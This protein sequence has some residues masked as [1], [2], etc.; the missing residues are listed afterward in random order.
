MGLRGEA[1][2]RN[3][4]EVVEENKSL[5]SENSS[6]VT[7]SSIRKKRA[8]TT[9]KDVCLQYKDDADWISSS[10]PFMYR[11][12]PTSERTQD[13]S[14]L[15]AKIFKEVYTGEVI[16]E[17][18]IN[19]L[20]KS[21]GGDNEY[22]EK[23][24]QQLQ[25]IHEE[26]DRRIA[27]ADTIE[28]HI[29]Q[30]RA[31]A[32]AAE[33]KALNKEREA[34][35]GSFDSLDLPSGNA[36]LFA[37]FS[38]SSAA[39]KPI[40]HY[41]ELTI[42]FKQ[43]ISQSP[44]DDGYSDQS[45]S[46]DHLTE[47]RSS[48]ILQSTS[49]EL[50]SLKKSSPQEEKS[51]KPRWRDE[52]SVADRIKAREDMARF[53]RCHNFLKNPRFLP[54]QQGGKSLII[55]KKKVQ[56][57]VG[58]RKI[59]V[60]ESDPGEPIPVFLAKPPIIL[61]TDYKVGQ[62][63]ETNVE[64]RNMTSSSRHLRI[65]PPSTT[66]FSVGLGKFPGEGGI[67]APGMS[68]QYT[69]RFAPDSPAEF[70]DFL[71]VETQTPYPLVIPIEARR[72][73]PILTLP[74]T[75]DCGFCLMGGVKFTEFLCR[76]EGYN[77]GCFCIM[78]KRMWPTTNF[79][80][81]AVAGFLD[82]TP[83]A[84]RPAVFELQPGQALILEVA[85]LPPTP[86]T[87]SQTVT[88]V[89]DNCHVKDFVLTGSGQQVAL[90]FMS[91]SGAESTANLGECR[92][93]TA[94]HFVR[95]EATNPHVCSQKVITL[96]NATHIDLP[97]CWQAL[98]PN[99]VCAIP[100]ESIEYPNLDYD[101]DLK[102]AFHVCPEN[103]VMEPHQDHDFVLTYFPQELKEYHSVL[104]LILRNIPEPSN[105]NECN[106]GSRKNSMERSIKAAAASGGNII[107]LEM[108][109][110]GTTEPFQV[111][112]KP[113]A[114]LIPGDNYMHTTLKR[115]FQIWNNS[116]SS[117]YFEW[118]RMHDSHILEVLPPCGT[119]EGNDYCELELLL[120]GGKPEKMAQRLQC[121][122]QHHVEPVILH[123]EA[124]FVGPRVCID[125]P[126]LDFCLVKFG[127]E[128]ACS[129]HLK[130]KCQL[131]ASWFLQESPA[132]LKEREEEVSQFTFEPSSGDLPPLSEYTVNV[133]FTPTKCQ[134]L[135]TVLE[136]N[137]ENG[138]A[139]HI[140]VKAEVQDV[141]VCLLSCT[142]VFKDIY[143]GIP[144]Q[145][146]A[147]LFNQTLLPAK[148]SWGEVH[149]SHVHQCRIKITPTSFTLGPNEKA[150]VCV[151]LTVFS[152]ED[153]NGA[154]VSCTVEDMNEPLLLELFA[155]PKGLNITYSIPDDDYVNESP[156]LD[157]SEMVVHGTVKRKLLIT[158]NSAITGHFNLEMEYFSSCPP[159]PPT[160]SMLPHSLSPRHSRLPLL[161][162][163]VNL[164]EGP[165]KSQ[166]QLQREF[167]DVLLCHK[168][169]A[170]FVV[171][172]VTGTLEPY[173]QR[174][175]E[176][177][178]Y[179]NMWGD[180]QDNLV[181]RVAG[182]NPTYIPIQL[183]VQGVP[184]YFKILGPQKDNQKRGP[185]IR[186][187]THISGG[188]TVSRYL[189][190]INPGPCDIRLDWETYNVES[191]DMQLVDLLV[192]YGQEFPVK[193]ESGNETNSSALPSESD[194]ARNW[195]SISN[196][197]ESSSVG[198]H[199]GCDLEEEPELEEEEN[200]MLTSDLITVVLQAHEGTQADYPYC[201]TPR[202]M[203]VPGGGCSIINVSFTP[204]ALNGEATNVECE[205]FALGF[206]SLDNKVAVGEPGKVSRNQGY[207]T[208]P[209][210]LDFSGDVQ[211]AMLT[212]EMDDDDEDQLT[213]YAAA[214]DLIPDGLDGKIQREILKTRG[215]KLS[216]NTE[217]P[218]CF[219][220]LLQTP[221]C[222]LDVDPKN[223][224]KSSNSDREENVKFL[225]LFPLQHMH[226][227]VA[228]CI[229]WELLSFQGNI[230]KKKEQEL[231]F[232]QDL[233][234]EY[235]NNS[236]QLIP[237][238]AHF[239]LPCIEVSSEDVNF[240]TC[241]VGQTR[242]KEIF[243]L[244]RSKSKSYWTATLV[245]SK[246]HK[247]ESVFAICPTCGVLEARVIQ[248]ASS[249]TTLLIT[250]TAR[251]SRVYKASVTIHGML[252]E[253]PIKLLVQGR[254]SVDEKFE[255]TYTP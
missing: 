176:V 52:L 240:G 243:L 38:I 228:F 77:A 170:A 133:L 220:F 255:A 11:H 13:I 73:P 32:A 16:G 179:A 188:D 185:M 164:T 41:P 93:V 223:T 154:M 157:F 168:K 47:D 124:T 150:V 90:H 43:R 91:V 135:K 96:R 46:K 76:N 17:D 75:L 229:S 67:V 191:D 221:F 138:D 195:D 131:A 83:F 130:N 153:L 9:T 70:E 184:L 29:I 112:L 148:C 226:V 19:N 181:C 199:T 141:R 249:R 242:K 7:S 108:E 44:V 169:G 140:A 210:R 145:E 111:L 51:K 161:K 248:L 216:N 116:S 113:Y 88:M 109:V 132:C 182:L 63:Y 71:I 68:C 239:F 245:P 56:K 95:F 28:K 128:A 186:F 193:D 198:L 218:L 250:F 158:N 79:R 24:V 165:S 129:L 118:E 85:F 86:G 205:G 192:F 26:Y 1:R 215:L 163:T 23:F 15:L 171:H 57:M 254:G 42:S 72:P 136:L 180:Y 74:A 227:T 206:L 78:P 222:V 101:Q 94:E 201:V 127:T 251:D 97:F 207:N 34:S 22:H 87:F 4:G 208:E 175:I 134:S 203:V 106:G 139:S 190:I 25:E 174:E 241:L 187:G 61:F 146:K 162:R 36:C 92:D 247:D 143:V 152:A 252:G 55:P 8:A 214:S 105:A 119:I 200:M 40:A 30:A 219:H 183:S 20:M 147:T 12:R 110:K 137:V 54:P 238:H 155:K 142:V 31:R 189:R 244:N 178:A 230:C 236:A 45:P 37:P 235:N 49:G 114:F 194:H 60:D 39:A 5:S 107:A 213:F 224:L 14:H 64:L 120:T 121:H 151:E 202:Q 62:V 50:T 126:F 27:E 100:G 246:R 160:V 253:R 89:C 217:T 35:G 144:A 166:D 104:Y 204:L 69:V 58:D 65:I 156:V 99:L 159:L 84:I 196:S 48:L 167:A 80:S 122:I 66:F 123:V 103:G 225:M 82:V 232:K 18:V 81:V 98:K 212:V 197:A 21:Q 115:Y 33:E 2:R 53:E 234:I 209:L 211:A 149:Q 10:E 177:T 102:T 6:A 172:P 231:V 117:I 233:V 173:Q 125:H 237:L 3:K 59:F